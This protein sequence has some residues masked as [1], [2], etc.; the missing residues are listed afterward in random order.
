MKKKGFAARRKKMMPARKRRLDWLPLGLIVVGLLVGLWVISKR[1]AGHAVRSGVAATSAAVFAQLSA[2]ETHVLPNGLQVVVIPDPS[3]THVTNMMWYK[4]G[5]A[6]DPP[7]KS[8]LGHL[9]EHLTSADGA[10]EEHKRYLKAIASFE[11]RQDSLTTYDF[12][13]YYQLFPRQQFETALAVEVH[14]MAKLPINSAPLGAPRKTV[15]DERR[16]IESNAEAALDERIRAIL[17]GDHPYGKPIV[18]LPREFDRNTGSD[19]ASF[20]SRHYGPN[21]AVM[22][23]HGP[24][25]AAEI[26]PLIDRHFSSIPPKPLSPRRVPA[27]VAGVT[28]SFVVKDKRP[29]QPIWKRDYLSSSYTVGSTAHVYALQ[30]VAELLGGC[31]KSRLHRLLV[32][33]QR[34]ASSVHAH[35]DPESLDRPTFAIVVALAT[36]V[37]VDALATSVVAAL[38]ALI[39]EVLPAELMHAKE[40]V[41]AKAALMETRMP[42]AARLVGEALARGRTLDQLKDWPRRID[43]VTAD[44][45]RVAAKALL[46]SPSVTAVLTR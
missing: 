17:Y 7:G 4:A 16:V 9:V 11:D 31:A 18:G 46:V 25:R 28:S 13:V 42:P 24:V 27:N 15:L 12:T 1:E 44:D 45:V 8:G 34:L 37:D 3:A 19:A 35:Y 33:R 23:V 21:N 20:Y 30:V 36:A 38:H 39:V 22:V 40:D 41:K 26:M 5:A 29:T 43:A 32:E 10:S 14:R 6:D 2:A